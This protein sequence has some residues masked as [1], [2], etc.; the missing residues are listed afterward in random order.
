[1]NGPVVVFILWYCMNKGGLCDYVIKVF[2]L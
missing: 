2:I 1:M